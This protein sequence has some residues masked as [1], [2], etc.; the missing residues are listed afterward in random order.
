MYIS[1]PVL[2]VFVYTG[3]GDPVKGHFCFERVILVC[4]QGLPQIAMVS[5]RHSCSDGLDNV[6]SRGVLGCCCVIL[7]ALSNGSSILK[8]CLFD[9]TC[10]VYRI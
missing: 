2:F 9:R 8:A 3:W 5:T 1:L 4:L 6:V 10:L 7:R